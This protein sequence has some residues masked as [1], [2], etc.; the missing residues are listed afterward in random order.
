MQQKVM[1]LFLYDF[2]L[3]IKVGRLDHHHRRPPGVRPVWSAAHPFKARFQVDANA[4]QRNARLCDAFCNL[5]ALLP[6]LCKT[7]S[8]HCECGDVADLMLDKRLWWPEIWQHLVT[9][10]QWWMPDMFSA[11][12]SVSTSGEASQAIFQFVTV[13][14]WYYWKCCDLWCS[15]R[16]FMLKIGAWA[17]KTNERELH[18]TPSGQIP[19]LRVEI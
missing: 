13:K 6:F 10:A 17:H 2:L 1:F 5:K 4:P 11:L 7:A 19:S 3:K 16:L 15:V 14:R 8:A 12:H 18:T 9:Q